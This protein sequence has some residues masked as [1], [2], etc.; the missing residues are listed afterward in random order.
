MLCAKP[1][2]AC[3]GT[4]NIVW[5]WFNSFICAGWDI[6]M[7]SGEYK[8]NFPSYWVDLNTDA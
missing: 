3:V 7:P 6:G 2:V 8:C 5:W 4:Y 1:Q